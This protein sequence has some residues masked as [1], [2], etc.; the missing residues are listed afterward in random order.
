[1]KTIYAN[2]PEQTGIE[3]KRLLSIELSNR[4][5]DGYITLL[6]YDKV[7]KPIT[8][9]INHRDIVV[10]DEGYSWL[11]H[12]PLNKPYVMI[13]VLDASQRVVLHQFHMCRNTGIS[14]EGVPYCEERYVS[15]VVLPDKQLIVKGQDELEAAY[16]KKQLPEAEMKQV[17]EQF[18]QLQKEIRANSLYPLSNLNKHLGFLTEAAQRVSAK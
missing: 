15:A 16:R 14:D 8:M 9:T 7:T 18:A 3:S 13:S 6:A 2:H 17:K 11:Q 5:Y 4:H 10:A 1:M 12:Y